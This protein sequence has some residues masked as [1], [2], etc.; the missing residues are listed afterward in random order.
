MN[1]LWARR[2][3]ACVA[4]VI[5]LFVIILLLRFVLG[6]LRNACDYRHTIFNPRDVLDAQMSAPCSLGSEQGDARN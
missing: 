3:G 6:I 4:L 1:P 2:V 5:I